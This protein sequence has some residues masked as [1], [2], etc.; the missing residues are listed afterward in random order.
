MSQILVL[1]IGM[2]HLMSTLYYSDDLETLQAMPFTSAQIMASKVLVVYLVQLVFTSFFALPMYINLG[3]RMG[4]VLYWIRALLVHLA[5]PAIPIALSLLA[6]V[7]IM[8]LT[9]GAKNRDMFRVVFGLLFFV[10][11]IGFQY[12]NTNV[13]KYGPEAI[14]SLLFERNGLIQIMAGYYVPVKWAA[15]AVTGLTFDQQGLGL[16]LFVGISYILLSRVIAFSQKWF[17]GGVDF[18]VATKKDAPKG[19][20]KGVSGY[21]VKSR[22]PYAALLMRE[23]WILTRTPNFFLVALINLFTF[24]ILLVVLSFSGSELSVLMDY[25]KSGDLINIVVLGAVG[26]HGVITGL[27]QIASTSLSREG[28]LFWFSKILP[29]SPKDQLR[30]KLGYSML[31]AAIQLVILAAVFTFLVRIGIFHLLI[32]IFMGLL[33][34]WPVTCICLLNDLYFPKLKWTEPQQAMKGNFQTLIAGLISGVYLFAIGFIVKLIYPWG[35]TALIYAVPF[36]ILLVSGF[37]LQWLLHDLAGKR[38]EQIEV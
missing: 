17:L 14:S 18:A 30:S 3:V 1:L 35:N 16:L 10:F 37:V 29:V 7:G 12:L 23:H 25:I 27:N 38:Y 31:F 20:K 22:S 2:S 21:T 9:R 4:T 15:N 28:R 11:I 19:A 26:F 24:P 13:T 8:R 36:L 32:L 33:V 6:V 5:T 34:S